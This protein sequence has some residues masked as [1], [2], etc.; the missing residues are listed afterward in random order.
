MNAAQL[1]RQIATNRELITRNNLHAY[2]DLLMLKNDYAHLANEEVSLNLE[3]NTSL[4]ELHFKSNYAGAISNS[5]AA[6]DKYKDSVYK[7]ITALHLKLTGHCYAHT[8][9]FDLAERYLL[10]A[11][12]MLG[13]VN[14]Q[15]LTYRADTLHSLAMNQELKEEGSPKSIQYLTEAIELLNGEKNAVR[16]ANSL[17]G[18]GNVY[19]NIENVEQALKNYQA[20]AETFDR[21]YFL[22]NLASAYCNIANCYIKLKDL[23]LAESYHEKSL[24]LRLK[25]GTPDD[26]SISYFNLAIVHKE[27]RDFDLAE[28][29]L[30]K[31]KKILEEVGNKPYLNY[32]NEM[33]GELPQLRKAEERSI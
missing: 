4:A 5:R 33:L 30:L 10:E 29:C 2:E 27:R 6:L 28:D 19:N 18:L 21:Q 17:M 13:P 1:L 8:G 26:I 14:E 32:V 31:C 23:E 11:L 3:L 12:D 25:F 24:A 9:E 22:P 16:R 20:A 15:N 7:N